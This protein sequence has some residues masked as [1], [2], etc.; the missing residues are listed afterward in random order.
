MFVGWTWVRRWV[1]LP[2]LL[3]TSTSVWSMDIHPP[4]NATGACSCFC[5]GLTNSTH[6]HIDHSALQFF[7]TNQVLGAYHL[8]IFDNMLQTWNHETY[9]IIFTIASS[10]I[11]CSNGD[12]T[13]KHIG[14]WAFE[15]NHRWLL[16]AF[17]VF[18]D[19][20]VL[21]IHCYAMGY[22]Y[23][24]THT[25]VYIYIIIILYISILYY[26]YTQ[27]LY[28]YIYLIIYIY[29]INILWKGL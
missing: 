2:W 16:F 22:I 4:K 25:Y 5:W 6:T 29:Y 18:L 19:D 10:T 9:H 12:L 17:L 15:C 27:Y 7:A 8:N 21:L 3:K 28:I 1:K 11:Y 23:M 13:M 26:I 14:T 20:H 24:H